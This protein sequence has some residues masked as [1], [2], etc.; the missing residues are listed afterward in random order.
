MIA[1][2]SGIFTKPSTGSI[3]LEKLTVTHLVMKLL[4]FNGTRK[5]ITEFTRPRHW[6]LS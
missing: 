4:A 1:I 2:S 6:T 5:F 3:V